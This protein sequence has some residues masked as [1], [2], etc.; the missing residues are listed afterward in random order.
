MFYIIFMLPANLGEVAK[1]DSESILSAAKP[2]RC[3]ELL[4][5]FVHVKFIVNGPGF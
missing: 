3:N 1:N 4:M 2:N 5:N